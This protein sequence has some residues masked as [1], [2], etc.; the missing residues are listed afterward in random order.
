MN[1]KK[2]SKYPRHRLIL[3]SMYSS[4]I[5]FHLLYLYFRNGRDWEAQVRAEFI[6]GSVWESKTA[7]YKC[8]DLRA[9]FFE[10]CG[11]IED[12]IERAGAEQDNDDDED[13]N[14]KKKNIKGTKKGKKS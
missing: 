5:I 9:I 4:I 10:K 7:P 1:V 6:D 8:S 14:T 3:F 2:R 12:A 13:D 11:E